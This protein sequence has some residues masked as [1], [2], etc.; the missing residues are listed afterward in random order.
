MSL[1]RANKSGTN[2]MDY[3]N[4]PQ[5]GVPQ[6]GAI[7][8][9]FRSQE[10]RSVLSQA[11]SSCLSNGGA[12]AID[13]ELC[14]P[15]ETGTIRRQEYNSLGD[16]LSC[17]PL[18][19]FAI[20]GASSATGK[21]AALTLSAYTLSEVFS[22]VSCVSPTGKIPALLIRI[23]TWP[24]PIATALLAISRALDASRRSDAMKSALPPAER[25]STTAFSPRSSLRPTT[26]YDVDAK[27][28]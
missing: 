2:K 4:D 16:L 18:H 17:S 28:A 13:G 9:H 5:D 8:P 20:S 26:T 22:V 12:T 27:L 21:Y 11:S 23:S 19:L 14:P 15:N 3:A 7:A 25:I 1:A 6:K 24:C 10:Y